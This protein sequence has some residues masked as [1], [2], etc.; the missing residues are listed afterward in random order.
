MLGWVSAGAAPLREALTEARAPADFARDFV[1]ADARWH[2]QLTPPEGEDGNARARSLGAP[3][4]VLLAG[5]YHLH[6]PGALLIVLPLVP[7][8][9][10]HAALVWLGL[11]LLALAA[12]G[13]GLMALVT[14]DGRPR[15]LDV[16]LMFGALLLWP[17]VLHN[18]AKGQWSI[19]MAALVTL[20]SGPRSSEAAPRRGG[21]VVGRGRV[22]EGDARAA[23]RIPRRA[24]A[25]R[26]RDTAELIVAAGTAAALALHSGVG[27]W[28]A[29]LAEIP[30]DVAV[31]QTWTANT[32]SLNGLFARLLAGDAFARPLIAAPARARAVNVVVSGALV[33]WAAVAT[34]RTPPS[35]AA[36]RALGAAWIALVVLLNPLAWTHTIVLALPALA[37]LIGIAAPW[38]LVAALALLSVP[39]QTLAALAGPTPV[40]PTAAPILSLHAGALLLVVVTALG[41]ARRE[42]ARDHGDTLAPR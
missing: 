1:T 41:C 17:P 12:L 5:P 18:L 9:F 16:A 42:R 36:D 15:A 39:R 19:A 24:P 38:P 34:W 10:A 29:W 23:A 21:R 11:S 25:A 13:Y 30:R 3:E 22:P 2:G 33:A 14:P 4:V 40:A 28:R 20:G 35:R 32:P 26:G 31:W 8:G 7:L 6:P 27:P 37:L